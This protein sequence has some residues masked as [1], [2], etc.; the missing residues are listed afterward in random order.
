MTSDYGFQQM[1][2]MLYTELNT[3]VLHYGCGQLERLRQDKIC[4]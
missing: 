4:K 3:E 2:Y 1:Q